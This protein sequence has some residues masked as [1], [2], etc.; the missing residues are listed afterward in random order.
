MGVISLGVLSVGGSIK[1][2]IEEPFMFMP[3]L[4]EILG[5]PLQCWMIPA[6]QN[7]SDLT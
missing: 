2:A 3:L 5:R 7:V 1:G 6:L 4:L